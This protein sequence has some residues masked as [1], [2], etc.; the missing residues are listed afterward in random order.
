MALTG[1]V[2]EP[3]PEAD[4]ERLIDA[5]ASPDVPLT[6]DYLRPL[7]E[8]V[9]ATGNASLCARLVV[10]I[11]GRGDLRRARALSARFARRSPGDPHLA[12]VRDLVAP[13][14]V[15]SGPSPARID[16]R[17][18]FAWLAEHA[19]EYPGEWLVLSGGRLWGHS[20]SLPEAKEQARAAGLVE[21]PLLHHVHA[22]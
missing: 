16:R 9:A 21:R 1:A 10:T 7:I 3:K 8:R 6:A 17:K 22:I 5:L 2:A 18:D 19:A 20:P 14:R 13:P 12:H 4:L 11:H 15:V